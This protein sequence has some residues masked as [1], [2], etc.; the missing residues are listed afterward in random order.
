MGKDDKANKKKLKIE[1][2]S[3]KMQFDDASF[4]NMVSLV[5]LKKNLI[6]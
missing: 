2:V 4:Y 6:F 5:F 3:T 1:K